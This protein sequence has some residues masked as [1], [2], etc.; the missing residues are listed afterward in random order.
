MTRRS[1]SETQEPEVEEAQEVSQEP[2]ADTAP[3]APPEDTGAS[4]QV[5]SEDVVGRALRAALSGGPVAR[6]TECWNAVQ[7]A[8]PAVTSSI[9]RQMLQ[10]G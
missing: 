9:N 7:A 2:E 1:K 8:I 5:L 6:N 10:E 3:P 4:S